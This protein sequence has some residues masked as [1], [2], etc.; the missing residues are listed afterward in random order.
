MQSNTIYMRREEKLEVNERRTGSS[1]FQSSSSLPLLSRK[2]FK[3][4]MK[5]E[6]NI[7]H[8][9]SLSLYCM[10][11]DKNSDM[12]GNQGVERF[13]NTFGKNY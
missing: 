10:N 13:L 5:Q 11:K 12:M 2:N 1:F 6:N 3:I 7:K 8:L 4:E 9:V